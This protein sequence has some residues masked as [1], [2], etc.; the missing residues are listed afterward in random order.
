MGG[1]V[2]FGRV[3]F[4]VEMDEEGGAGR[5]ADEG[6]DSNTGLGRRLWVLGGRVGVLGLRRMGGAGR[7]EEDAAR[8]V[9]LTAL[10][11]VRRAGG[12]GERGIGLRGKLVPRWCI[13]G[14]RT[15]AADAG[16]PDPRPGS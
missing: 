9:Y 7:G 4:V 12:A 2:L 15:V 8:R 16:A 13:R 5:G 3:I 6:E 14:R 10:G 1:A 11:Q